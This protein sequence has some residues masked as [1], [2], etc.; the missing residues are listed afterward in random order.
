MVATEGY[1]GAM[2]PKSWNSSMR[3]PCTI[4]WNKISSKGMV[5]PIAISIANTLLFSLSSLNAVC[6]EAIMANRRSSNRPPIQ[7]PVPHVYL[8]APA[9]SHHPTAFTSL[10]FNMTIAE[11][12]STKFPRLVQHMIRVVPAFC[13]L[14][15]KG[16]DTRSAG[17]DMNAKNMKANVE[18]NI[19]ASLIFSHPVNNSC[20][21]LVQKLNRS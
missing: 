10:A 8:M 9:K 1:I 11:I 15:W 13:A 16:S 4:K 6:F 3:W 17:T 14:R 12:A 5:M 2:H 19:F 7:Q 20:I 18:L 21:S